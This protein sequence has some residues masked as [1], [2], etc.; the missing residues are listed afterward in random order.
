MV[1]DLRI[2]AILLFMLFSLTRVNAA[3]TPITVHGSSEVS[4]D[5]KAIESASLPPNAMKV[6][7]PKKA[8]IPAPV[9]DAGK[10]Q[11]VMSTNS[12]ICGK[13]LA[14][15]TVS[16]DAELL[17]TYPHLLWT[18]NVTEYWKSHTDAKILAVQFVQ[19]MIK[20]GDCNSLRVEP[21]IGFDSLKDHKVMEF[22]SADKGLVK[23]L[24]QAISTMQREK[25]KKF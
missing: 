22:K 17:R 3:M 7:E 14:C 6:D 5:V 9:N 4:V 13:N 12:D 24:D 1:I 23:K 18:T 10:C 25:N 21:Y 15:L 2:F 11:I 8:M 16:R 19:K 20:T